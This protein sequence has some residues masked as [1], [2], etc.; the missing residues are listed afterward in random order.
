MK[1]EIKT[2]CPQTVVVN[3][4][5]MDTDVL[6][7]LY[8]DCEDEM[9]LR[10]QP[11]NKPPVNMVTVTT[12]ELKELYKNVTAEMRMRCLP[13]EENKLAS[14]F[15]EL[16]TVEKTLVMGGNR[17]LAIKHVRERFPELK[18]EGGL[19]KAK[20]SVD[21]YQDKF[22]KDGGVIAVLPPASRLRDNW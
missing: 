19:V 6:K 14:D 15:Y 1:I 10:C 22:L 2:W 8:K 11:V 18:K 21:A 13:L 5:D 3:P 12:N 7:L 17:I 9:V 16:D 20:D 4:H